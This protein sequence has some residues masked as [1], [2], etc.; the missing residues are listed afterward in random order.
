M[1]FVG[2]FLFRPL[3]ALFLHLFDIC[4]VAMPASRPYKHQKSTKNKTQ[5]RRDLIYRTSLYVIN[6]CEDGRDCSAIRGSLCAP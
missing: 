1:F 4:S 3:L 6:L 2:W 5:N